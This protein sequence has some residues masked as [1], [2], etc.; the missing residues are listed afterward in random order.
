MFVQMYVC[1]PIRTFIRT[2]PVSYV[3]TVQQT[4]SLA[5]PMHTITTLRT[6]H[7]YMF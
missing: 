7:M 4:H 3:H 6:V 5:E 1:A 2:W